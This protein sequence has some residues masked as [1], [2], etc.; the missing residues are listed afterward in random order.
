MFLVTPRY[1][2]HAKQLHKGVTRFIDYKRDEWD[3]FMA[4]VTQWDLDTYMDCLP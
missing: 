4:T 2:K 3:K 1:L